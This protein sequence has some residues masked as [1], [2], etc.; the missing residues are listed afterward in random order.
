VR[1]DF[2]SKQFG[3]RSWIDRLD[4]V[5]LETGFE[6]AAPVFR[7]APTRHR[8]GMDERS[9]TANWNRESFAPGWLL[10]IML[11]WRRYALTRSRKLRLIAYFR[12]AVDG[13]W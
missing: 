5:M 13:L 9:T 3:E 6:A 12:Q 11:P 2:R 8:C 10:M 4:E 7:P 1:R